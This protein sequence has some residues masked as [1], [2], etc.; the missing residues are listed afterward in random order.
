[1]PA[2][3]IKNIP[4]D[5]YR[6]LKE[7]ARLNRRSLNGEAIVLLERS[8]GRTRR[9]SGEALAA[10]QK[11]HQRLKHLP[12]LDDEFLERAKNQGRP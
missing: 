3:T 1:M 7:S 4:D 2:L 5:V 12:P 6:R 11:L 8:L 9:S 10:L